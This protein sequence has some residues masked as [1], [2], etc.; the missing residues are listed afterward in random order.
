MMFET[1]LSPVFSA[2]ANG[3]WGGLI[4]VGVAF[5]TLRIL[6]LAGGVNAA[7]RHTVWLVALL[8]VLALHIAL[9]W[10]AWPET[11]SAVADLAPV[12]VVS[13]APTAIRADAVP[14]EPVVADATPRAA[15]AERAAIE[16]PGAAVP[17]AMFFAG[18]W[19]LGVVAAAGRVL[20]SLVR[21]RSLKTE[22]TEISAASRDRVRRRVPGLARSFNLSRTQIA[23][24]VAA[25]YLSPAVLV[26]E[27]LESRMDE[28]DFD[29]LV[30]HEVAHIARRDDW[31]MLLQ[32]ALEALLWFNPAVWIVGRQLV[33]EREM[34]CDEWVVAT[35]RQPERYAR[36][37]FTLIELR[38]ATAGLMASPGLAARESEIVRRVRMLLEQ[39]REAT[40]KLSRERMA[41]A[42]ALIALMA[43]VL[44]WQTPSISFGDWDRGET[45]EVSYTQ[46]ALPAIPPVPT[47][48]PG[49][50]L[51]PRADALPIPETAPEPPVALVDEPANV[52][53][54]EPLDTG[55]GFAPLELPELAPVPMATDTR[56]TP[57][58]VLRT[59]AEVG[60]ADL[61]TKGWI[62]LF[63][64]AKG[65]AS[66]GDRS[67]VLI[68][69]A[70]RMPAHVD[71]HAAYLDAAGTISSS[72]DRMKTL[73]AMM[74]HQEMEVAT[75][76]RLIDKIGTI[77]SS[78]DRTRIL[79]AL[80][81]QLPADEDLE[82]AFMDAIEAIPSS[83]DRERLLRSL[84]R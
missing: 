76:H 3:L 52:A 66:S 1:A 32:R 21:L 38:L 84:L 67:R 63:N 53:A 51:A 77:A 33:R 41:I 36:S 20:T 75:L 24:P 79:L 81:Q 61:T 58:I 35:T 43:T 82:D 73:L 60:E 30:L 83:G 4:I 18:L 62:R 17:W 42:G 6:K 74:E 72:S 49:L 78:G 7:T 56:P 68:D 65:I 9:V 13:Q 64:V 57:A 10:A 55:A 2:L 69:A 8:G 16:L 71:I 40:A 27:S 45:Q 14:T 29:Q 26:P 80:G 37:L 22:A 48:P 44:V 11:R 5:V 15:A 50:P 70:R 54:P 31:T 12:E 46:V 28:E 47:P 59:P 23:S 25:G 34:A 39:G 19:V